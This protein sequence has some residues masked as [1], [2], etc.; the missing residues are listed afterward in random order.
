VK[1]PKTRA[2]TNTS[3]KKTQ[4]RTV[5]PPPRTEFEEK[6]IIEQLKKDTAHALAQIKTAHAVL[7][8]RALVKQ[9][10]SRRKLID[11]AE[12]LIERAEKLAERGRPRLLAVVAKIIL[13]KNLT[14]PQPK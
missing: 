5:P 3:A 6:Q 13:D 14:F 10:A 7:Q 8:S 4:I 2:R 11:A 9:T 12:N 1:T